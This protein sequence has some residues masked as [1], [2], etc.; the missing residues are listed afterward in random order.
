MRRTASEVIH[1]LQ[2]RVARLERNAGSAPMPSFDFAKG[3][4][5]RGAE[6]N[7]TPARLRQYAKELIDAGVLDPSRAKRVWK[8]SVALT[9]LIIEVNPAIAGHAR[10]AS[11][12]DEILGDEIVLYITNDGGLYRKAKA[13]IANQAKHMM[14]GRWN[15]AGGIKGFMHLV[16]D[17]IR[18]YR[19]DFGL[20]PVD[21]ATKEYISGQLLDTYMEQIEEEAGL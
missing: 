14:K 9:N 13:I 7:S 11:M 5:A 8:D 10:V 12:V 15:R 4:S 2:Q 20:G 6:W 1:E 21:K 18:A 3:P 17:G 16:E 19:K